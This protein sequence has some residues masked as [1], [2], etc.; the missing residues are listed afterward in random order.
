MSTQFIFTRPHQTIPDQVNTPPLVVP[1]RTQIT[2]ENENFKNNVH[3][4]DSNWASNWFSLLM[5]NEKSNAFAFNAIRSA[6]EIFFGTI[7]I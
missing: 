5:Q 6:K 4:N 3:L 7:S 1:F 2:K